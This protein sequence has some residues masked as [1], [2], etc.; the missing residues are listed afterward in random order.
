MKSLLAE[1]Q[2]QLDH[3]FRYVDAASLERLAQ[4]CAQ[5]SGNLVW[6]GVG[7]S[8][9]VAKKVAASLASVGLQAIDLCPLHALHGDIG[10]L[11]NGDWLFLLSKSGYTPELLQLAVH[12]RSK[13]AK[14]VAI[15][16]QKDTPLAKEVDDV[17]LLP[18][19][20]ELCPLNLAPTTSAVLQMLFGDL[21][22]VA[23]MRHKGIT[24][25]VFAENHPAGAIGNKLLL[26]VGSVMRTKDALPLC[27]P[28][29]VLVDLLV[30]ISE[31]G[32]GA[33]LVVNE[34]KQLQGIFTDGDLRRALQQWGSLALDMPVKNFMSPHPKTL[35][36][37]MTAFEAMQLMEMPPYP[38]MV[39]PVIE[40]DQ[41]VGIVKM[42]DLVQRG[43][44]K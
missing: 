21:L 23:L 29:E 38:V 36:V 39:A 4:E 25:E 3:F 24:K 33:L 28:D 10:R 35:T 44:C 37:T 20:K 41:V 19:L 40:S 17:I 26:K 9:W 11:Q 27:R 42:H 15:V 32:C 13:G 12:A 30:P 31:K 43:I 6:S 14:T 16:C 22:L 34:L 2:S 5:S 1:Y 7:K 18:C 8:G